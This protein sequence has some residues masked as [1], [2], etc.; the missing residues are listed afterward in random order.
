[1]PKKYLFSKLIIPFF[2]MVFMSFHA[3]G[4]EKKTE[5]GDKGKKQPQVI[6]EIVVTGKT[7]KQQPLST[8]SRVDK[9]K[10]AD[11]SSKDLGD[12]MSYVS[13]TYVSEGQKNESN[14]QV[15]G[16]S[17]N[18]LTLLV[19]GVPI[20]EPYFNSFDLNTLT[21]GGIESV[22]VIKGAN[23]VLYGPNT[24][25]GVINVL[26]LRPT[27]PALM[28]DTQFGSQ[29]T[30]Q[31]SGSGT[32]TWDKF[33]VFAGF[34]L[35]QSDGF[36]WENEGARVVRD[37]SDY[38][39]QNY[40]AKFYYYP[41][42]KIEFMAQVMFYTAEYGIPAATEIYKPRY[43]RFENW[44]RL[45]LNLGATFPMPRDG[46]LRTRLYYVNHHNIL[47]AYEN[48]EFTDLQWVSTYDNYSLG[49]FVLGELPLSEK[50]TLNFS[51]NARSDAVETQDDL[52]S[53]WEE[54]HHQT[55]SIGVEDYI[56]LSAQWRLIGGASIDY[57]KKQDGENRT[58]LN[59]ILGVKYSPK[60][61]IDLHL[62]LSQKSRFPSMRSLYS[63][64]SG[65]PDLRDETGRNIEFGISVDRDYYFNG[66]LFF[67]QIED[68]IQ[69][70]R[71]LEGYKNYDNVGKAEI[72]GF[73]LEGARQF[74]WFYVNLNYTYLEA[75]DRDQDIRLDYVP[76]SQFNALIKIGEI[77]GFS[78]LLWGLSV[79]RSQVKDGKV[80]PF[81][82]IDIPG[83]SLVNASLQKKF[84]PTVVF[85]KVE[86]LLDEVYFTEPG[87]PMKSRTISFGVKALLE[88]K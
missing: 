26:S 84:G 77:K 60:E 73:E 19:D 13:G 48:E 67:N 35:D 61:W 12:V 53:E 58:R 34:N 10:L 52:G 86:N 32:Y 83:Y 3:N 18:R 16:L 63:T 36:K 29:S 30:F 11:T 5:S 6:E 7:P 46:S 59:P 79:S 20:Y 65:N 33:D 78:L 42:E 75:W 68:L 82:I 17:S 22:K 51:L 39:K 21:V 49:A 69:A 2:L 8:V 45:Q 31:I 1:M 14:I 15:R 24:L 23:S 38:Q 87:F 57:L 66:A 9:K 55:Y 81:D 71:G 4:D 64:S 41:T 47:D 28:L 85:F 43:W 27:H 74:G 62:S 37:N 54:F 70:Y 50:N 56:D 25:G 40:T 88:K 76:K 72:Y 80:P 44:D